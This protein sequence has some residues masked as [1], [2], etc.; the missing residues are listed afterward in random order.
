M[1]NL[2]ILFWLSGL[3]GLL[4]CAFRSNQAKDTT[5]IPD[6]SIWLCLAASLTVAEI[7]RRRKSAA[8][9]AWVYIAGLLV[10]LSQSIIQYGPGSNIYLL[11]VAVPVLATLLLDNKHVVNIAVV[12]V[13]LM[14]GL[15]LVQT[16]VLEAISLT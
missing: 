6:L 1:D 13:G 9:G 14:F 2:T 16:G 4:M 12:S 8:L 3:L 7:L 11:F 15:T 10:V 5:S